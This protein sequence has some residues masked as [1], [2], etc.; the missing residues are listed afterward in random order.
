[1][2]PALTGPAPA[3]VTRALAGL[4]IPIYGT[5]SLPSPF[6]QLHLATLSV[7]FGRPSLFQTKLIQTVP[8]CRHKP[9][10]PFPVAND[11][12]HRGYIAANCRYALSLKICPHCQSKPLTCPSGAARGQITSTWGLQPP[13]LP[14][15][16]KMPNPPPVPF[17]APSFGPSTPC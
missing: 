16:W 13:C 6:P 4:L 11:S 1:M 10:S 14:N 17:Q 3:P 12:P 15:C 2:P 9:S 5:Q 8:T 7:P